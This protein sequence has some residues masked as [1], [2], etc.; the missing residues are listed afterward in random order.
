[1]NSKFKPNFIAYGFDYNYDE[2]SARFAV[3]QHVD[4]V[5]DGLN[6]SI[7]TELPD[8]PD[9]QTGN[10]CFCDLQAWSQ[11]HG[12]IVHTKLCP[13]DFDESVFASESEWLQ[14][15]P[16]EEELATMLFSAVFPD[17]EDVDTVW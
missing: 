8:T 9:Y 15:G 17:V 5:E 6:Y 2:A 12:G 10:L 16:N 1:M 13:I 14:I 3:F 4:D 7:V 11:F